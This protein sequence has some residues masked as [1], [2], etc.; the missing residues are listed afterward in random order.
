[1]TSSA[2]ASTF[3]SPI[4]VGRDDLL[5]LAERRI[6]EV[7]GGAGRLLLLAGEAGVGKTRLL[8]AIERQ[9]VAAGFRAVRGGTYPS[10]LRVSAAILIDLARAMRRTPGLEEIGRKLGERLD[11]PDPSTHDT[12]RRRRLLVLDVAEILTDVAAGGPA[13][14]SLE[15]LHW[16]DD[17][18]LET[19]E[20]IARRVPDLPLL[21]V[22]T[23]R[24]DELFPRVPMREWRARLVGQRLAEE[25]RL[26]RLS[27]ADTATMATLLIDTGLP[28]ARDVAAAV[29]ARTDGIPLHVE[30]LI[31]VLAAAGTDRAT[32]DTLGEVPSGHGG[33]DSAT[34]AA[35][36]IDVPGTVEDT[37]IARFEQRSAEARALARAGAVI[38]RA[39]DLELLSAVVDVE[40]GAMSQPLAELAE[41]FVLLPTKAPGR[42]G[43]RHGLICDAIYDRIPEPERR[44]LHGR[45]ADAAVG[46]DVGTDAFLALHYERA[47]RR[48]D[49]FE[50]A[51]R[52]GTAA[53]AISS[54]GAARDL[55][56]CAL[57]TAPESLPA[58]DRARLL[59]AFAASAA[60]SDDNVAA[61]SAL[62]AAQGA[63]RAAGDTL[64]ACALAAP[65]ADIRHLLGDPL[66]ARDALIRAALAEMEDASSL[67][68]TP[69]DPGADRVRARLLCA[70]AAAYMLDRRLEESTSFAA[71]A[72]RL[73]SD[74]GDE[75][76]GRNAATTLGTCLMF[77]GDIA[78]G[79]TLLE[80]SIAASH[81]AHLEAEAARA[82]RMLG[83]AAS[84]LGEYEL[85]EEALRAGVDYA[86]RA[87]L[88]NHRHYMA[89]H[90]AHVL[91]ATGRWADAAALARQALADGRGGV[92]TRNVALYV[93]G[94]V[95]LSTGDLSGART[96]LDEALEI[97]RQMGELQ[98]MSP[99][100]WGLAEV[101]L[102]A[103]DPGLAMRHAE[104]ALAASAAVGDAAYL[105]PFVVTATR[106]HL[107]AGDTHAARRWLTAA[108]PL[109]DSRTIPGARPALDHA[110]GLLALAEG[111]TGRARELLDAAADG[112]GARGRTWEGS[113]AM[114]DQA[115]CHA[116]ANRRLD[117]ARIA[118]GVASTA[119]RLGAPALTAAAT[120]ILSATGRGRGTAEPWAP[121]TAREFEV[122]R[123]VADGLTNPQIATE[124]G[125]ATKTVAAH[126]EH[127]LARL[128]VGR[129]AEIAAW[130]ASLPV[131]HSRPHDGD[132]EE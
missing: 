109:L 18:T 99:A 62:E 118:A 131:L 35:V 52:G 10:D 33:P 107:A 105:I 84:V 72:R 22:G 70:R 34:A 106:A 41:Q 25:I 76:T 111:S 80:E 130:T 44:R 71:E 112:W 13:I 55:Y 75:A 17:L 91:W 67:D 121:L 81:A 74:V 60:A 88:W 15:D 132:R 119:S 12:H 39:F 83:S 96:S 65:L 92:T 31:A 7:A 68:R 66:E 6:G 58:A 102:L 103:G 2:R 56:A 115:R 116:R 1:M 54:H 49:A 8:G 11:D 9:A 94:Y 114:L 51:R 45:T 108:T 63:F 113:W 127:I 29:H 5:A 27:P 124:L 23:Y 95:A 4:L 79:R 104:E 16:S 42:Y 50:A 32:G 46:T 110:A 40:P 21:V 93:L 14:V 100:L 73:A 87:E 26:A 69:P 128:G 37:I 47:G 77:E 97:G 89:A 122:A 78:S 59:A 123:L 24:S 28:I 38:G 86:E 57:R 126:V 61:S 117:A 90:L 82:Y 53:T 36:Q 129:R 3:I 19:V 98:R 125:V 48:E 43:F 30:E 101:A 20:A 120:E 64:A 85:A